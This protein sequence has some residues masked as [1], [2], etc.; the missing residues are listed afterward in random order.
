MSTKT[1]I[2]EQPS[3]PEHVAEFGKGGLRPAEADGRLDAPAF[4]RNHAA[5]GAALSKF[6]H[7]QSGDVLEIGSGTGQHVVEFARQSPSITWWPSDHL[8]GHLRSIAA[9]RAH[10]GLGNLRAP[11][12][13]D[14]SQA[15]WQLAERG[16]PGR[17]LGVFCANVIHIA[18]W[19]VAEG[20]FTGAGRHL[21][22][23]GKLFLYG[24]F[25]RDGVHNSPGNVKFDEGLRR[26]NP[27]WGVRDTADLRALAGRTG[28]R[29]AELVEM[30]ANNAILVFA[31]SAP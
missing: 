8:D 13:L 20:L 22:A 3:R 6:L 19:A 15:D 17:F 30:P 23:D 18:P 16:L 2:P 29:L 1:N 31:P 21:T 27:D 5:I 10:A 25:R 26:D 4:H 11:T 24:P 9:W 12:R 14:C 7:G 28:L